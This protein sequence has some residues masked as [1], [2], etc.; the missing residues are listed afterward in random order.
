MTAAMTMEAATASVVAPA[1]EPATLSVNRHRFTVDDYHHMFEAGILQEEDRVE[2]LDGEILEMSA[3]DA[4]H[5]AS[6]NRVSRILQRQLGE[7][8]IISV[9]NP[10]RINDA[11]EP[12]PDIAV[13]RWRDDFYAE[14]HPTPADV[15]LLI[16]VANTS[17]VYDR[18]KKLPLYAAAAIPEV[19]LIDVQHRTI[20]QYALPINGQY[21]ERNVR[22]RGMVLQSVTLPDFSLSLEQLFGP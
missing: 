11:S 7:H 9:Q 1:T 2:L 5:A 19:W 13:L 14:Q 3:V 17:L 22:N 18:T 15:M 8:S 12:Q 10:V 4:I 6:V 21:S 16:E 20:E